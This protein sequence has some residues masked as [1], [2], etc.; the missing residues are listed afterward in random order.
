ML[1]AL[2]VMQALRRI[3]MVYNN[4]IGSSRD[5]VPVEAIHSS[6]YKVLYVD[7]PELLDMAADNDLGLLWNAPIVNHITGQIV[8]IPRPN[9]VGESASLDSWTLINGLPRLC[10]Y[11]ESQRVKDVLN[12]T[13]E[14]APLAP[15]TE[16]T[17]NSA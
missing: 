17:P 4:K 13:A 14:A 15:S 1:Y 3:L 16:T 12:A 9:V 8:D 5:L 7:L 11:W 6:G 10:N 2:R